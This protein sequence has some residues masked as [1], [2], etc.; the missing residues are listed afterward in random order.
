VPQKHLVSQINHGERAETGTVGR[1]PRDKVQVIKQISERLEA[2]YRGYRIEG[3]RRGKVMRLHVVAKRPEMP[4]LGFSRFWTLCP[5]WERAVDG[6]VQHIDDSLQAS[7]VAT[8]ARVSVE[9]EG[10][11]KCFANK[12]HMTRR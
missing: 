11:E 12:V 8:D 6:I 3:V 1:F 9:E 7:I 4:R 2:H 5:R 10:H